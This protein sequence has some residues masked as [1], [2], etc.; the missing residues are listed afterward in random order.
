MRTVHILVLTL[1]T[2]IPGNPGKRPE[3]NG[4]VLISLQDSFSVIPTKSGHLILLLAIYSIIVV[5]K[6]P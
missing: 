1:R 4:V 6:K 2:S 3:G 5:V